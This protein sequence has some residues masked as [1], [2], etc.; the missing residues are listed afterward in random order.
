MLN[1]DKFLLVLG[2]KIESLANEKFA[3]QIEF[4]TVSDIDSRTLRRIIKAQQNP[5][6]L[7]LRKISNALEI[8][9]DE[10]VKI[11]S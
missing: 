5:T 9:L 7:M 4:S 11:E 2:K 1:D 10:L 3:T 8:S 6:I